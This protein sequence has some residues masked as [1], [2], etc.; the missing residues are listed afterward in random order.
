MMKQHGHESWQN[1]LREAEI[2]LEDEDA[3]TAFRRGFGALELCYA[4][5]AGLNTVGNHGKFKDTLKRLLGQ[6]KINP[7]GGIRG[8]LTH[9]E[10]GAP[11]IPEIARY[12]Y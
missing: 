6:R 10:Y 7:G 9:F 3:D 2:S 5:A 12:R 11:G 1:L 4:Q 8:Q